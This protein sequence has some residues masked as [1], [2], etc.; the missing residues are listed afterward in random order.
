MAVMASH[1]SRRN[2]AQVSSGPPI[3]AELHEQGLHL[4]LRLLTAENLPHGTRPAPR[5]QRYGMS[6]LFFTWNSPP[7]P[8]SPGPEVTSPPPPTEGCGTIDGSLGKDG[9]QRGP[10][11]DNT[12]IFETKEPPPAPPYR[13]TRNSWSCGEGGP[14]TRLARWKRPVSRSVRLYVPIA[15]VSMMVL[16]LGGCGAGSSSSPPPRRLTP[17]PARCRPALSPS[18]GASSGRGSRRHIQDLP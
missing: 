15:M 18:L 3:F 12:V 8:W 10:T 17:C 6:E 11:C 1:P 7:R 13:F 4:N 16:L 14:M 9:R 5:V 2:S